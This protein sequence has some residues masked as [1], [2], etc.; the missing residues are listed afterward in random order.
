MSEGVDLCQVRLVISGRAP[1]VKVNGGL[2][3]S[4]RAGP[5]RVGRSSQGRLGFSW[6]SRLV[7]SGWAGLRR[8][9]LSS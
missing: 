6:L 8:A 4:E 5:F 7:S 3:L 9:D 1:A 2:V